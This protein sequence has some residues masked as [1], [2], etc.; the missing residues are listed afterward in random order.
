M[1]PEVYDY[2][3]CHLC[4]PGNGLD[5]DGNGQFDADCDDDETECALPT[6]F[7]SQTRCCSLT[8]DMTGNQRDKSRAAA[9]VYNGATN[10]DGVA[11]RPSTT[12]G[13]VRCEDS[14]DTD[15]DVDVVSIEIIEDQRAASTSFTHRIFGSIPL[16]PSFSSPVLEYLMFIDLTGNQLTGGDPSELGFETDFEGANLVT[17]AVLRR[18]G[19]EFPQYFVTPTVWKWTCTSFTEQQGC[20]SGRLQFEENIADREDGSTLRNLTRNGF[21]VHNLVIATRFF[22]FI[23][24]KVDPSQPMSDAKQC[25]A[26]CL[27]H[28]FAAFH[29]FICCAGAPSSAPRCN[30]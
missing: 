20:C 22:L 27:F 25:Q 13:D 19:G 8:T 5:D 15:G 2:L 1:L 29:S 4:I 24:S 6:T 10:R 11:F 16:F 21:E 17:R 30:Q 28:L 7:M 23:P 12:E 14:G 18:P 9:C 26:C 3:T